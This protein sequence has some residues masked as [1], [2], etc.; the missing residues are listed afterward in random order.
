MT[1]ANTTGDNNVS[2]VGQRKHN[3]YFVN[4]WFRYAVKNITSAPSIRAF[5]FTRI[6]KSRLEPLAAKSSLSCHTAVVS[7]RPV[8]STTIFQPQ[9]SATSPFFRMNSLG[10]W[11]SNAQWLSRTSSSAGVSC[12]PISHK[13][14]SSPPNPNLKRLFTPKMS[15][16]TWH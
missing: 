9:N 5:V 3:S 4:K 14:E 12:R 2:Q 8:S 10:L 7:S 13:Q 15:L 11:P 6:V 1:M 16:S